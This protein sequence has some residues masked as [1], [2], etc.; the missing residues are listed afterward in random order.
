[1]QCTLIPGVRSAYLEENIM[2]RKQQENVVQDL[3]EQLHE[4]GTPTTGYISFMSAYEADAIF[5]LQ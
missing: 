2:L 3:E 1:M 5:S 4:L